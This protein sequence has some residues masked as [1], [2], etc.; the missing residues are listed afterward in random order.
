VSVKIIQEKLENYRCESEQEETYAIK[1][2]MQEIALSAFARTDFFKYAAFQG[3]TA[4][5][6]LYHLERF[7]ED[8]DFI[9]QK[10]D[11]QFAWG[12]YLKNLETEFQIY[13]VQIQVEDRTRQ[14]ETV[15]K[16][17]LKDDSIG[18]VLI[19][20][21]RPKDRRPAMVRVKFELD[22]HPPEGN[23]FEIKYPD[24]PFPFAVT[25]QDLPSLFAGKSHALLCREYTKGRDWYD[26]LWYVSRK[27]APNYEFLSSACRQ[28]GPW[29]GKTFSID[30]NWYLKELERKIRSTNWREAQQDVARFLRPRELKTLDLWSESFFSDR[31]EKL[32]QYL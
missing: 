15:K 28:Q 23:R 30:R 21:H 3:G 13:G 14:G 24:F 12:E 18:K 19:L 16:A 27:I 5:R 6:I 10:P 2:I 7:S 9:L 29:K 4:L 20:K 1:E 17:F 32:K 31:V 25:V 26:F 22:T 11:P 8:L